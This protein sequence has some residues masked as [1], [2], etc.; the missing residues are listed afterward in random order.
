MPKFRILD[1]TVAFG[2]TPPAG[3]Q[4]AADAGAPGA[5]PL[6]K[7]F[8]CPESTTRPPTPMHVAVAIN[9]VASITATRPPTEMTVVGHCPESGTRPPTPMPVVD[10]MSAAELELLK[11]QLEE[12]MQ[13]VDRREEQLRQGA[14]SAARPPQTLDEVKELEGRLD[15]ALAELRKKRGELEQAAPPAPRKRR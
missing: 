13:Q 12:V 1:L 5:N 4:P 15:E 6:A 11:R 3:D 8:V 7:L 10:S 2:P 9:C 14:D